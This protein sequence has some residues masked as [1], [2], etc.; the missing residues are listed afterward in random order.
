MNY[1]S[2]TSAYSVSETV[3]KISELLRQKGIKIIASID[4]AKAAR[5]NGLVLADEVL[6][7]FGDPKVGTFLMQEQPTIGIDLPLKFLVWQDADHITHITYEDPIKL[8]KLHGIQQHQNILQKMHELLASVAQ[9][10]SQKE[11]SA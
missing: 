5:D 3:N 6:L 9:K 1:I 11:S 7:I 4:H 10:A 8:G 2:V